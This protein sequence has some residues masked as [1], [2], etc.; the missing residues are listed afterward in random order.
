MCTVTCKAVYYVL[1]PHAS[2]TV[3]LPTWSQS[4]GQSTQG[5]GWGC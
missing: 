5:Q 2:I 4:S 3:N 1:L